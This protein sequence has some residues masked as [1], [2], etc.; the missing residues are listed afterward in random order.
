MAD[1]VSGPREP[2][3]RG[4][5]PTP[6][7]ARPVDVG[8]IE[9]ELTKLW[10]RPAT[11]LQDEDPVTRACMSNLIVYC[12]T[13]AEAERMPEEIASIVQRHPS[14]VLLLVGH[15]D[16]SES[17][18]EAYVSA[19]CFSA[20]NGRQ[21]CSE[22]VT[23][24]A[25]AES[26]PRLPSATRALLIGD[27]PT[28]LWWASTEPPPAGGALFEELC[29]MSDHV[30]Y[31]SEGWV[32]PV[33]S[34]IDV[35]DWVSGADPTVIVSDLAW[36]RLKPWR[37]VIGQTLDPA[38]EPGALTGLREVVI[39]H[40]P[41]A[42]PKAWLLIGWLACRLDWRARGGKVAPGVEVTFGFDAPHGPVQVTVRRHS[43]GPAVL[44]RVEL[45]WETQ[46][47]RDRAVFTTQGGWIGVDREGAEAAQRSLARGETPRWAL[48]A[49]QLP[50]LF[51][52][53]LFRETL[54]V[55]RT[56]AEALLR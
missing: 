51:R 34:V 41:H 20:G 7:P 44:R 55:S 42:L 30:I 38:L 3:A 28:A 15:A 13:D 10:A 37:R 36:R 4:E 52:D 43:E 49:R 31:D 54:E 22:H 45:G 16:R 5:E 26:A 21:I 29:S 50:K 8:A 46:G 32:D 1:A 53:P 40:G 27:L 47:R 11:D 24:S 48:V 23:I 33:R 14:R 12:R 25:R 35:A 2:D 56:M 19:V 6:E 9:R 17:S 18:L 39:E